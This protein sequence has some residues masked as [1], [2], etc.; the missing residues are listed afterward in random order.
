MSAQ[1]Y[2]QYIRLAKTMLNHEVVLAL[3]KTFNGDNGQ[4]K[5][6][7]ISYLDGVWLYTVNTVVLPVIKDV[8]RTFLK[9]PTGPASFHASV[10][11]NSAKTFLG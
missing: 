2:S 4:S 6:M 7:G 3:R 8:A 11:C 5:P 9:T 1:S 10:F